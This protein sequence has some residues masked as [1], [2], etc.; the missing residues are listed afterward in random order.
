MRLALLALLLLTGCNPGV[1][2][3]QPTV[4]KCGIGPYFPT[5]GENHKQFDPF[6]RELARQADLP[7]EVVTAEDW[8]GISEALRSRHARRGLARSVGL[9]PCPPSR[10]VHAGHRHG[11]V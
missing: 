1:P 4:L 8:I 11:Q 7:A 9:R 10:P 6:F 3:S 5:P 2:S